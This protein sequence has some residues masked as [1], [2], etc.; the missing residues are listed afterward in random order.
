MPFCIMVALSEKKIIMIVSTSQYC[1]I[2]EAAKIR[3][4]LQMYYTQYWLDHIIII[5]S[6]SFNVTIIYLIKETN[7]CLLW[8][9]TKVPVR[10]QQNLNTAFDMTKKQV[11]SFQALGFAPTAVQSRIYG[12][13]CF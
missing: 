11:L 13:F 8:I 12:I 2:V 4:L 3:V 5:N 7:S 1:A 9:A 6:F 10:I